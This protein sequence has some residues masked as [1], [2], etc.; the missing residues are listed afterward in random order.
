MNPRPAAPPFPAR[1]VVAL[2]LVLAVAAACASG[3]EDA[4]T[5]S[6]APT[7]AAESDPTTTSAGDTSTSTTTSTTSTPATTVPER[8]SVVVIG[9]SVAAGEGIAYGYEYDYLSAEPD[10]SYWT[11]GTDDPTWAGDHPLCH[12]TDQAYGE[13]VATALGAS[14]A[15]F[16]CTGA[17]YLNGITVPQ[18]ADGT[19]YRPAQF[20]TWSTATDLNT[21]Y[22][23]AE[24]DVVV[25][26]FGADDVSFVE[27]IEFCVTGWDL[28]DSDEVAAMAAADDVAGA[29]SSA[30]RQR[31]GDLAP[32]SPD[33]VR[34]VRDSSDNYC[35]EANPGAP[36]ERLFWDLVDNGELAQHYVDLVDAIQARGRDPRYGDGKVPHI[37]FTTYHRPLPPGLDGDCWDV[38]PLSPAEQSYLQSLQATLQQT[39]ESAV[40]DLDG[41][42]IADISGAVSGHEW[43]TEDPWTYGL[44][45]VWFDDIDSQAP[46]HPTPEGQSAIA[47]IV[48]STIRDAIGG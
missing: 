38:Y 43:C 40:S 2:V 8:L 15:K 21:A 42:S 18:T 35:T 9:D 45:T 46:F 44:S 26:T 36:I 20:G 12:Q 31:S 47:T 41:V 32:S 48:E 1:G 3:P 33:G 5:T 19:T 11:G 27:I 39:L 17:T 6:A 24:P 23:D 16:A 34:S 29:V 28:S 4:T 14:L 37:V 30:F 25:L 22:D 10:D 13:L 7:T